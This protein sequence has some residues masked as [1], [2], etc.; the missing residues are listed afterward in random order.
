MSVILKGLYCKQSLMKCMPNI[1][2]HQRVY[3]EQIGSQ[4]R[5]TSKVLVMT[6]DTPG[7]SKLNNCSIVG[8]DWG[9]RVG[10]VR[11]GTI[12]LIL[13]HNHSKLQ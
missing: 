1:Q 6:I 2:N 3:R 13:N 11:A 12:S 4:N 9:C 5:L 10:D 8:G 7:Y